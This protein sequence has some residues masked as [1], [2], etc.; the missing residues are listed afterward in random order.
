MTAATFLLAVLGGYLLG[1]ISFA[2]LVGRRV[3]PDDDLGRT[4][5]ELRDGNRLEYRGVS[6]TSVA[7]RGG[8]G[9]GMLV[10]FLDM[11]KAAAVVLAFRL[12]APGTE[13]DL[14]AGSAAIAGHNFPAWHRF[15]GGRGMSPLFG[16][17]L[18]VDWL[19][20]PSITVAGA[21]FGLVVLADPYLAYASAPIFLIP[22]MWWRFGAGP[23][24]WFALA[25][26][27]LYWL[28]TVPE[29]RV[30]FAHRRDSPLPRRERV[31]DFQTG[32]AG[33]AGSGRAA[34][35]M[36]GRRAAVSPEPA[37]EPPDPPA[38]PSP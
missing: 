18:V 10:G 27:A 5:F 19:S 9:P 15:R 14:V 8:P 37:P 3:A 13:A 30:W 12:L 22:W 36:R 1:S 7:S 28:A 33:M 25:T 38:E 6:A 35:G 11:A 4:T 17:L 32:M 23:E 20:V 24:L 29:L 16:A 31:K 26:N 2:R 34:W 21:A